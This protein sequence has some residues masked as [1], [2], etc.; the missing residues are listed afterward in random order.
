M[1][2][3]NILCWLLRKSH[4]WSWEEDCG[5]WSGKD[6]GVMEQ[7]LVELVAEGLPPVEQSA[8]VENATDILYRYAEISSCNA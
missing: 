2:I 4:C 6:Y 8:P 3:Q 5:C 1:L 7:G